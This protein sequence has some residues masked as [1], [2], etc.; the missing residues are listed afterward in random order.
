MMGRTSRSV[1]YTSSGWVC[2]LETRHNLHVAGCVQALLLFSDMGEV[3]GVAAKGL[4][5][6][7]E[8]NML[9]YGKK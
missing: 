7:V 8:D 9:H 5:P 2:G 4:P 3:D 6:V 1:R